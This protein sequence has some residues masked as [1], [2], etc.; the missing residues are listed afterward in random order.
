MKLHSLLLCASVFAITVAQA[1]PPAPSP[2]MQAARD[3]VRKSCANDMKSYCADK[4]GREAMQCLHA[5]SDKLSG[6]CKDA[7]AKMPQR[8]PTS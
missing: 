3:A 8:N 6:D 7:L 5:N 2:E 4:K 1:Q